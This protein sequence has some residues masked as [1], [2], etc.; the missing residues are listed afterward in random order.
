MLATRSNLSIKRKREV[1]ERPVRDV[2]I[3]LRTVFWD[4]KEIIRKLTHK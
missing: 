2:A 3:Q 4:A 1:K